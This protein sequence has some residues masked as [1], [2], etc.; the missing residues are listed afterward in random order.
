MVKF[1]LGRGRRAFASGR[2]IAII[3]MIVAGRSVRKGADELVEDRNMVGAP[4]GFK[5]RAVLAPRRALL[6]LPLI[7]VF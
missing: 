3:L 1:S 6:S 7:P 2:G 4:R 5:R